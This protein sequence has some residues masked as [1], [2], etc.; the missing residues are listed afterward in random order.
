MLLLYDTIML[1]SA[2]LPA[3][4]GLGACIVYAPADADSGSSQTFFTTQVKLA[5][6][7]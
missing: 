2:H 5:T 7:E 1:Y 6:Q 4:I 3:Y